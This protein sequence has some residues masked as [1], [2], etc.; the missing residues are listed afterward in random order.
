VARPTHPCGSLRSERRAGE[1][2]S[3]VILRLFEVD[4]TLKS[5]A[6][7]TKPADVAVRVR[8]RERRAK[9][10]QTKAEAA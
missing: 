8:V 10:K 7:F 4:A 5:E 9:P 6:S 1:G 3:E 2:Y